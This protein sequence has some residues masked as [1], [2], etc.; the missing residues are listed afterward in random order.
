MVN[1]GKSKAV[2]TSDGS[3][4]KD[5]RTIKP[6][7]PY[8]MRITSGGSISSYVDFAV[9]FLHDNPHT[10]LTLHTLPP[11]HPSQT[12]STTA[13]KTTKT[14]TKTGA[15]SL[16]HH[17]GSS[18]SKASSSSSSSSSSNS[19]FLPCTTSIPRLISVVEIIKRTYLAQLRSSGAKPNES[20]V[21]VKAS[22]KGKEVTRTSKGIW[23]YTTSD[24]YNPSST[25]SAASSNAGGDTSLERVLNG[26]LRPKMTHHPYMTITLSTKPLDPESGAQSLVSKRNTTM[27]FVLVKKKN[28]SKKGKG[29]GQGNGKGKGESKLDDVD[30][31]REKGEGR[32]LDEIANNSI[33]MPRAKNM[34]P[35]TTPTP[36]TRANPSEDQEEAEGMSRETNGKGVK[37]SSENEGTDIGTGKSGK[38]RKTVK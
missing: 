5:A 9:R 29:K 32:E 20:S 11:S 21:K 4:P 3:L 8:R 37:R 28:R 33:A 22:G 38:K 30:A 36:K 6:E 14:T 24:L 18:T 12:N 35:V 27:E 7:E 25:S 13:T 34:K 16:D 23:Q 2:V 1:K 10:P 26:N 15:D 17:A 31:P 19:T